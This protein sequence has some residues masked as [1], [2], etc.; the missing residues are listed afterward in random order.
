MR[1][2]W[3]LK[4]LKILVFVVLA[5]LALAY[6]VTTLWNWLIPSITGFHAI[7]FAQGL[8][9]LVLCRVLFGGLRGHHGHWGWRHRMH[10]RWEQMSPED[11]ERFRDMMQS[12]H[13]C[14]PRRGTD[15]AAPTP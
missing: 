4:G 15:T 10:Q 12:H 8:A 9:L 6:L 2:F 7:S 5:A 14:G 13:W 3:V 1:R 11:R